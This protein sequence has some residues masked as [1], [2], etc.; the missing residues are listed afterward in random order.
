MPPLTRG[1]LPARVYWVRRLL[2]LGIALLLVV[3]IA[4]LLGGGSDATDPK[5]DAA[6]NVST[7][8]ST[9]PSS[10]PSTT[11]S[12]DPSD[13]TLGGSSGA[14]PTLGTIGGARGQGTAVAVPTLAEPQGTCA[15][16]DVTVTPQVRRAVAGRNVRIILLLRTMTSEACT[17]HTG[18]QALAV[19]ITSGKDAIWSS[20]ECPRAIPVEDVVVRRDVTS[21]I[22]VSWDA[23]R[24]DE[25]CSRFTEWAMPG[26]YHVTAAALGAEPAE[27][28]FEL[29][30]PVAGTITR[31]AS[32][33]QSPSE[34]PSQSAGRSPQTQ[35]SGRPVT[36]SKSSP[37]AH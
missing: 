6:A 8:A 12:T 10:L 17:W 18:R 25:T 2:V 7:P 22:P 14:L 20:R 26:F 31:T 16:D 33:T 5:A 23:R 13:P 4:R 15:D 24:S 28:Q 3:G 29:T 19:D 30:T 34:S 37:S 21:R 1:P 11:A 9:T 27:A 32:P 35:S 36:T